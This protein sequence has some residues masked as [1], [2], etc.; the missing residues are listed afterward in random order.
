M[1]YCNSTSF[2]NVKPVLDSIFATFGKVHT[3]KTDNGPPFHGHQFHEYAEKKG[4]YHH[5]ITPR[6]PR[7]N[8]ECERFMQYLNKAIRIAKKENTDYKEKIDG[9]LEA[10]R[11]TP[12]PSTSKSP[13]ELMFGRKMNL[14]I[15]PTMKR[16]IKDEVIRN[17]DEQY[18]EKAKKYY[19]RKKN[20]KKSHIRLGD[21]VLMKDKRTDRLRPEVGI[22]IGTTEHSVTVQFGNGRIFKRDKS[23]IKIVNKAVVP[24]SQRNPKKKNRDEEQIRY[25]LYDTDESDEEEFDEQNTLRTKSGRKISKSERF[26]H[27]TV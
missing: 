19:D 27:W 15:F 25:E 23:H 2:A 21:R 11:A 10:Y 7:A 22:I 13:F 8:G 26:G 5:K 9:M 20:V 17:R 18:K 6:H 4:F 1:G 24:S 16:R 14:N 3:V 12:H